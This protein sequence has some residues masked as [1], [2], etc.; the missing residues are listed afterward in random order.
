MSSG[1]F[2]SSTVS[3]K[4]IDSIQATGFRLDVVGVTFFTALVGNSVW[5]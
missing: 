3:V 4:A 1:L 5:M 2:G